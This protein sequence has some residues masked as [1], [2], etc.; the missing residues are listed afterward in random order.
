VVAAQT[1]AAD[2]SAASSKQAAKRDPAREAAAAELRKEVLGLHAKLNELDLWGV[3]GI[4]RGASPAEVKRAYLK[5]A[6]RLHPDHLMRLGL[7]DLKETANEVFTQIA[8]AHEVLT[9]ADERARYEESTAGVTETQALLAAQAEQLYQ[10][11]DMLMRAGNFR[12]AADFLEKAVQ[13]YGDEPEYHAAFAW[14][15]HRKLPPENERALEHFEVALSRGGEQPQLM[16]RM[17]LVL[18][19]LRDETRASQ[20]AA[21]ARQLDPN[22]RP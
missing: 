7:E 2:A 21:R 11:G 20:L 4:A 6:K 14:A 9:D 5:A 18:K 8:R 15:L 3:L 13:T 1:A 19:E 22:V 17:S 10:R 16:L 12:G